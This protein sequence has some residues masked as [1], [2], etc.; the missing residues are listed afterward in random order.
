MLE[1]LK[2]VIKNN[3]VNRFEEIAKSYGLEGIYIK[4]R[5]LESKKEEIYFVCGTDKSKIHSDHL[6]LDSVRT[7]NQKQYLHHN[8]HINAF[9]LTGSDALFIHQEVVNYCQTTEFLV[10]LY[11][12]YNMQLPRLI[13]KGIVSGLK[14]SYFNSI[15]P[16]LTAELQKAYQKDIQDTLRKQDNL[17][18]E[19]GNS[20]KASF[21]LHQQYDTHKSRFANWIKRVFSKDKNK[22]SVEHLLLTCKETTTVGV[23][24]SDYKAVQAELRN[25]PEIIY[26]TADKPVGH[27]IDCPDNQGYGSQK[28]NDLRFIAFSFDSEHCADFMA[29]VNRIEHPDGYK[30]TLDGLV[31]RHAYIHHISIPANDYEKYVTAI[32]SRGIKYCIE[33]NSKS[34]D[35]INIVMA[36]NVQK[37]ITDVLDKICTESE[38][39]HLYITQEEQRE[40]MREEYLESQKTRLETE[41][42]HKAE[43]MM[44][45][46]NVE[47]VSVSGNLLSDEQ[48]DGLSI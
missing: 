1:S 24:V 29:I 10:K 39:K 33:D 23:H 28:A 21:Y 35:V 32:N 6:N 12:S 9:K 22:V 18:T 3:Y 25:H 8:S 30:N 27:K 20:K 4:Y 34:A 37:N 48:S 43:K 36:S 14:M 41:L 31:S 11:Q 40:I 19:H 17:F 38:T 15:N 44:G 26:W 42:L 7:E 13:P 47:F 45:S 2:D 46:S 16:R 5:S